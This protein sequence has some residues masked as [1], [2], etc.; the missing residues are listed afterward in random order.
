MLN[1]TTSET[2]DHQKRRTTIVSRPRE[3]PDRRSAGRNRSVR[4]RGDRNLIDA[5]VQ[6]PA[7]GLDQQDRT[8]H[9]GDG[10]GAEKYVQRTHDAQE[11]GK[12]SQH[13]DPEGSPGP[14]SRPW[15]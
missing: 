14:P 7:A 12:V 6:G 1:P 15:A 3:L 9:I 8:P 10:L 2:I 5:F 4:D 11:G 13:L